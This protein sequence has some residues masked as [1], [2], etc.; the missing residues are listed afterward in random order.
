MQASDSFELNVDG[1]AAIGTVGGGWL[2]LTVLDAADDAVPALLEAA[3]D[4]AAGLDGLLVRTADEDLAAL[5]RRN[6]FRPS[7]AV[8]GRPRGRTELTLVL[9]MNTDA[10]V[11]DGAIHPPKHES[12]DPAAMTNTDPKGFVRAVEEF[13]EEPFGLYLYRR[14]DHPTFHA[15]ESWVLP[16]LG[17]RASIFYFTPGHE[18]DQRVYLDV[19]KTWREDGVWHTEDWYLDLLEHPGRPVELIDVD[20]LLAAATAE[21]IAPEDAERA[22]LIATR[23]IAGVSAHGHS[24]DAWLAAEGAPVTWR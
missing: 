12:F 23:A 5:L 18:R 20:E 21:L 19:V 17:L 13:R 14:S 2:D 8:V 22:I 9:R 4:R 10:A 15:I 11:D 7:G 3:R 6:G 16:E 1:A 24:V